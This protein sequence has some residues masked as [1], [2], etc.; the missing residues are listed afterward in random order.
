MDQLLSTTLCSF[1]ISL[2]F[3]YYTFLR[4][5]TLCNVWRDSSLMLS[6][7]SWILILANEALTHGYTFA[8]Y[9]RNISYSR[10]LWR[11]ISFHWW[12]QLVFSWLRI[13]ILQSLLS[14][15]SWKVLK[16]LKFDKL[17]S[18]VKLSFWDTFFPKTAILGQI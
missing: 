6:G 4:S 14:L 5:S 10:G 7:S 1:L 13:G 11:E 12:Y 8:L 9:Q 15:S 2:P 16:N 17:W 18:A 3:L